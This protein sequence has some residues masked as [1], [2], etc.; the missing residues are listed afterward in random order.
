M[1][2]IGHRSHRERV[3]HSGHHVP[4]FAVSRSES[5]Q[6]FRLRELRADLD[7]PLGD[8]EP[9]LRVLG[10]RARI[11]LPLKLPWA[12]REAPIARWRDFVAARL[13]YAIGQQE[14]GIVRPRGE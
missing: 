5:G 3:P 8:I 14:R 2:K 1:Y 12:L 10:H 13:P 4:M 6:P 11:A 7:G 9:A